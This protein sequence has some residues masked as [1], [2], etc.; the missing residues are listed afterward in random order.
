[1]FFSRSEA[2]SETSLQFDT[3]EL[4]SGGLECEFFLVRYTCACRSC[5]GIA[6]DYMVKD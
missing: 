2:L 1:M 4:F 5:L 3:S 6:N